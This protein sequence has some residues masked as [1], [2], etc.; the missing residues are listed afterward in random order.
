MRSKHIYQKRNSHLKVRQEKKRMNLTSQKKASEHS[1]NGNV[2]VPLRL[3]P[4]LDVRVCK[5]FTDF[6]VEEAHV[7]IYFFF[8]SFVVKMKKINRRTN[9]GGGFLLK[10]SVEA[11]GES[12]RQCLGHCH[13]HRL[14]PRD[15][16]EGNH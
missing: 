5:A 12:D 1:H 8:L 2:V 16:L 9:S 15:Y 11:I 7:C 13:N 3:P 6:N 4:E 10:V 14:K